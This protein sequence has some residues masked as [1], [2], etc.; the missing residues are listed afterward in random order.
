MN[1][2]WHLLPFASSSNKGDWFG[3]CSLLNVIGMKHFG[4]S[5]FA[6]K[7]KVFHHYIGPS[8]WVPRESWEQVQWWL[9]HRPQVTTPLMPLTQVGR[10]SR[11]VGSST[12]FRRPDERGRES[13]GKWL[14]RCACSPL[15]GTG[16][17]GCSQLELR[18][19]SC[20]RNVPFSAI[21][22]LILGH[23]W[24]QTGICKRE[25]KNQNEK[26]LSWLQ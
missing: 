1:T 16:N 7:G 3:S 15:W 13:K 20:Y 25:N 5:V 18:F 2:E 10:W 9:S 4:I 21:S 22:S 12:G 24:F 14:S 23:R 8:G 17:K 19:L 26:D 6:L 11:V